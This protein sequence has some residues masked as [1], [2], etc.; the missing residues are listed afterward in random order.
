[1]ANI[2]D[3]PATQAPQPVVQIANPPVSVGTQAPQPV[4]QIANPPAPR[5]SFKLP[6]NGIV[7]VLVL[8]VLV[9]GVFG[10]ALTTDGIAR[11]LGRAV[12]S[13]TNNSLTTMG[14]ALVLLMVVSAVV[15]SAFGRRSK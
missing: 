2:F 5:K 15:G 9:L 12:V 3:D 1:M 13:W 7:A 14:Y 10:Q 11:D 4:V 6:L 8:G